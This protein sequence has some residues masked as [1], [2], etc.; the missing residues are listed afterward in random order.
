ML[1]ELEGAAVDRQARGR[2]GRGL[3]GGVLCAGGIVMIPW[4][5]VLATKLP[6]TTL[7]PHWSTAWVGLDGLEAVG[8]FT[9]GALLRRRDPRAALGAAATATLL[10]VDAWFDVT[11]ASAGGER[12]VAVT[13]AL[14][15]ELP[16]YALLTT[17][18]LRALRQPAGARGMGGGTGPG[19]S[20][21]R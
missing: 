13:M 18:A 17:V 8:L 15:A 19:R 1:V 16:L 10:L 4:A 21:R 12:V 3:L 9:T 11:T 5:I 2:G 20:S 7:V 6:A 14:G